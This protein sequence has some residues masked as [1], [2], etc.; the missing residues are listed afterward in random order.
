MKLLTKKSY[1]KSKVTLFTILGFIITLII[2]FI[3]TNVFIVT[4]LDE[5][6]NKIL[7]AYI[8][9]VLEIFTIKNRRHKLVSCGLLIIALSYLFDA[10]E[11]FS[12]IPDDSTLDLVEDYLSEYTVLTGI[13]LICIGYLREIIQQEQRVTYLN[14]ASLHDP[15]TN[16]L[17]R[18]ALN[19][20]FDNKDQKEPTTFCYIDLNGFKEINDNYG[21][22]TGDMLLIKFSELVQSHLRKDDKLFRIGGD[23]F[24]LTLNTGNHEVVTDVIVRIKSFLRLKIHGYKLDF[25]YGYITKSGHIS[26]K[27]ILKEADTEMYKNKREKRQIFFDS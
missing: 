10:I 3:L 27:D 12:I 11:E 2:I 18:R 4:E 15:L 20:L 6:Y 23:E 1:I 16:A 17:N 7:I 21:H 19:E 25:S 14:K 9:V 26:I 8:L 24:L 22:E 13:I 5:V